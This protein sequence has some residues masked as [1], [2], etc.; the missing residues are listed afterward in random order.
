M[1][2]IKN[3]LGGRWPNFGGKINLKGAR[4]PRQISIRE[5][6]LNG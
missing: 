5:K 3:I 6:S 4:I 1:G 2:K